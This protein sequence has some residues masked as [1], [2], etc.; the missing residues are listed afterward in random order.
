MTLSL[1][2]AIQLEQLTDEELAQRATDNFDAFTELYRR[3]A[4]HVCNF[5]STQVPH[6]DAVEDLTAQ[7]FFKAFDAAASYRGD[8]NYS[9]W[10]F[11]I[12]RNCVHQWRKEQA[13]SLT[14]EVVPDEADPEPTPATQVLESEHRVLIWKKLDEL[15]TDQRRVVTLRYLQE[16]TIEEIGTIMRRSHGAVRILLFRARARLRRLMEGET[17]DE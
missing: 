12:A 1:S 2:D 13:R 15:T 5:I 4:A 7:V 8:G 6:R 9:A 11:R 17:S 14:V 10:L 3:Y 16:L